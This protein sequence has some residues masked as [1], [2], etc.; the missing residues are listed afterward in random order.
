MSELPRPAR[1]DLK[2]ALL[3][4][5]RWLAPGG[6]F[7]EGKLL[8]RIEFPENRET[9]E[10]SSKGSV[11]GLVC[12][13]GVRL[14]PNAGPC[15]SDLVRHFLGAG[16]KTV[17]RAILDGG[18]C[19]TTELQERVRQHIDRSEFYLVK[20]NLVDRELIDEDKEGRV[21]IGKEWIAE[22]LSGERA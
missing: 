8:V 11:T 12:P 1:R 7:H 18:P 3:W 21:I 9:A 19:R 15:P 16:E 17:L 10:V 22:M 14:G 13:D 2:A 6:G 20:K 5:A 4:C